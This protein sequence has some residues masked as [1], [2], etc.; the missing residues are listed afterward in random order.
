MSVE[1][2]ED[3]PTPVEAVHYYPKERRVVFE[4]EGGPN[5]SLTQTPEGLL[6]QLLLDRALSLSRTT[7]PLEKAA[8]STEPAIS[9]QASAEVAPAAESAAAPTKKPKPENQLTQTGRLETK[10]TPGRYPDQQGR[11]TAYAL[12]AAHAEGRDEAWML[13]AT[14][15]RATVR[16][17]LALNQ[18]DQITVEGF[19]NKHKD[20]NKKDIYSI[21]RFINYPSREAKS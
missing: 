10:P 5:F 15:L 21:F 19:V 8:Q 16:I 20:Q 14:F 2:S 9:P 7:P 1:H 3:E 13:S 12:L 11:P 18:G 6:Y 4:V 17:A